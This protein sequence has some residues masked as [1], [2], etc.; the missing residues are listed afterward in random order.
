M[1]QRGGDVVMRM[2]AHVPQVTITPRIEATMAPGSRIYTDA[3]DL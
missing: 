1:I 3:Y 2:L